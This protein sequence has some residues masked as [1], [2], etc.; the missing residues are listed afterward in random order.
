M[1]PNQAPQQNLGFYVPPPM[2]FG[3]SGNNNLYQQ[4]GN[5]GSLGDML[6]NLM[7]S[8]PSFDTNLFGGA[9]VFQSR[10]K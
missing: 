5:Q 1:Y 7:K 6:N 8:K 3:N 2:E 4:G 10:Y 9:T